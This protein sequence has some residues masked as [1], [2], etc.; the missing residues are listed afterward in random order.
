MPN[1]SWVTDIQYMRAHEIWLYM[2]TKMDLITRRILS[3]NMESRI[4]K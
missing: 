4:S 1:Q 2:A 3:L